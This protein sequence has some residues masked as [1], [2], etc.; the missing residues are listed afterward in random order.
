MKAERDAGK[1]RTESQAS[2]TIS[3]RLSALVG[4]VDKLTP[5]KRQRGGEARSGELG[6]RQRD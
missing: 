4:V 1:E 6:A 3:I 5:V 2:T